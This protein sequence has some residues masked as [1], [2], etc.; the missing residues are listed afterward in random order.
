LSKKSI[1]LLIVFCLM[2][3]TCAAGLEGTVVYAAEKKESAIQGAYTEDEI[4]VVFEEDVTKRD[5]EKIVAEQNGEE[6]TVVDTPADE[7]T[8]VVELPKEQTV[9]EAVEEYEEDPDVAYAQPNYKYSLIDGE[10]AKQTAQQQAAAVDY[11]NDMERG[12]LWHLDMIQA[13]DAWELL[14]Q[15]ERT[16][17]KVAV[18]D[19]GVDLGHEDL[20][21]SLN[22]SLCVDVTG[23]RTVPLKGDDDGHGTHVS[24]IIAA[25]ANN[26]V[27]VAG[28]A[29]GG[30][31]DNSV[32]EIFVVDVFRGGNA[33]TSDIISGL[34]YAQ[35]KGAKVINMSLGYKAYQ[36]TWDDL[37]LEDTINSVTGSNIAVICAAGNDNNSVLNYP[38]DFDASISVTSVNQAGEK[39]DFSN[40]GNTKDIAAPGGHKGDLRYPAQFICS[41]LPG[42]DYSGEA[43]TSMAAPVVSGV[44]ALLYSINP[45]MT[46]DA[47][48][49][50][51][52]NTAVDKG[53]P[54]YDIYYG[55]GIVN[56]YN[57]VKLA[58]GRVTGI[59]LNRTSLNMKKGQVEGLTAI[60]TP[61][62][63]LNN[64]VTWKSS[65]PSVATVDG[66]GR[67][68]AKKGGTALITVRSN[69]L[70]CV[71]AACQVTVQYQV[72]YKLNGGKNNRSNPTSYYGRTVTLKKPTRKG[73]TFEGWYKD[74]KYRK[75]V[76]SISSGDYTLYAKWKKVKT[77]KGAIKALKQTSKTKLKVSQRKVSGAKGYQIAYSTSKKFTKKTTKY[78]N[79]SGTSKTVT[80]LK[81]GK[82]YY[83]KTRAY[84]KDSA[85][86]KV[87]GKYSK[88]RK[89]KL[90]K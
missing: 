24:G 41:T 17:I 62:G 21:D 87:Y 12:M 5:A 11:L 26:G 43:G 73:Y 68:T 52:Y 14:R 77:G 59:S 22:K 3:V 56:A 23:G 36:Q 83:V 82:T 8:G 76:K 70:T 19:T 90:K 60:I 33:Y 54:G 53:A 1:S 57:A 72:N 27:G 34:R 66:S 75:R 28:V 69:D 84:K 9:Q 58:K 42:N 65:N 30:S 48:K 20:Q 51:L 80:K 81:P 6:L 15:I 7:V 45:Q 85:G 49:H 47:V 10:S 71:Y 40:Y 55:H 32:A 38:A 61:S 46:L 86:K 44:A 74:S 29:S 31:R 37:L 79:T 4:L 35:Q 18:L 13:P 16:R 63:A 50:I 39:S 88:V 2:A 64:S 78:K 67:V 89:L 25:E